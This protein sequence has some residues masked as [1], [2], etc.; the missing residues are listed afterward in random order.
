M[1]NANCRQEVRE[2]MHDALDEMMDELQTW[3]EAHPEADFDE[4]AEQVTLRWQV[5]RVS[6]LVGLACQHGDG[7]EV[8]GVVS[9]GCGQVL[10]YKGRSLRERGYLRGEECVT[11]GVLPLPRV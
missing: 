5:L 3:Q 7:F 2:A 11:T 10:V 4:I 9:E 6:L 8:A 1:H